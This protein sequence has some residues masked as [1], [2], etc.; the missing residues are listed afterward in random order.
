VLLCLVPAFFI[1]GALSTLV[2]DEAV[3][4]SGRMPSKVEIVSW[5][6]S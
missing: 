1:T 6:K 2:I 5:L 3:K 4:V